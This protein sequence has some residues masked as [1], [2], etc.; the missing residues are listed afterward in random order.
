MTESKNWWEVSQHSYDGYF[1]AS[2][3]AQVG[4]GVLALAGGPP[5]RSFDASVQI[6]ENKTHFQ[7]LQEMESAFPELR[8]ATLSA[9]ARSDDEEGGTVADYFNKETGIHLSFG[10]DTALGLHCSTTNQ[11]FVKKFSAWIEANSTTT[12]PP[13]RVHVMVQGPGGLSFRNMGIGGR[14]IERGN[15]SAKV[16]AGVDRIIKDLNSDNPAGRVAI[17]NGKPGTGK[18]LGKDTPVLMFDGTIKKVQDVEVGDLLMGDDSRP[19]TVLSL[20][21]GRE[22][23]YQ[24]IPTKGDPYVVNESHI[25]SLKKSGSEDVVDISVREL[26]LKSPTFQTRHKGYRVGVDFQEREIS[27]DPYFIGLWLG[28]GNS[29]NQGVTTADPEVVEYLTEFCGRFPDLKLW[30]SAP[31]GLSHTYVPTGEI[32]AM[33]RGNTNPIKDALRGMGLL[34]NKH[35]PHSYKA[36]SRRVRLQ[37]LAG[38]LDSDGSLDDSGCF[39]YT[40]KLQVL[41]DDTAFL[42]RSLGLAAY[43]SACVKSDQ[44]GSAGEYFRVCISGDVDIIP[45]KIARKMSRPRL[46][47]KNVLHTGVKIQKLGVDDYFGF[48]IDGNRRFLLGDFTV[49]H[50]TYLIRGLL[51]EIKNVTMVIVPSN[52]VAGLAQPEVIP[53]LTNLRSNSGS[54]P[55]VFL[56]EDADEVV[57]ARDGMNMSAVSTVLNLGDGILGSLLDIRIVCTT[58]A[59]QLDLD[60][61]IMRPGR[62]SASVNVGELS[63]E[64]AQAVLTR[65]SPGSVLE[66]KNIG[67]TLAEVYSLARNN[68]WEPATKDRAPIGFL[69]D[70]ELKD[71]CIPGNFRLED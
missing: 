27:L 56:I 67:Y 23:M 9:H 2:S 41:A 54:R 51:N 61:A 37:V 44:N 34:N 21:R 22:T 47:I 45:T 64:E 5:V 57:S 1:T 24:I 68:G 14:D 63:M 15:Y 35:I 17:L 62:L 50:N 7:F 16:L 42:A 29:H 55:I 60:K 69:S 12:P 46:Q 10:V 30:K 40:S 18:C 58:N 38:L 3:W 32:G 65:L 31:S 4:L 36:N 71:I 70:G 25:L 8:R 53:A 49:T 6:S 19:R 33:N 39:D 66:H 48:E 11:D 26:L 52:L 20:A 28:D 59:H 13:G 43:V